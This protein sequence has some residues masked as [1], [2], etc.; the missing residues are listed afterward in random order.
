MNKTNGVPA[1][2]NSYYDTLRIV[3]WRCMVLDNEDDCK[4]EGDNRGNM[5]VVSVLWWLSW[6]GWIEDWLIMLVV[7]GVHNVFWIE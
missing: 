1:A 6:K 5:V 4:D 2:F 7:K 3:R